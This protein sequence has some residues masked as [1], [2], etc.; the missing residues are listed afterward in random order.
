MKS[1]ALEC[2]F[3]SDDMSGVSLVEGLYLIQVKEIL[4]AIKSKFGELP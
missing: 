2:Q 4:I 1:R 3:L